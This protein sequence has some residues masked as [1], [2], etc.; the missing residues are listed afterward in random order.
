MMRRDFEI[1]LPRSFAAVAAHRSFTRAS[2]VIGR[3]QSV[4]ITH[5]KEALLGYAN[6]T[7]AANDGALSHLQRSEA[8]GLV[9]IDAPD[10]YATL[11]LQPILSA[12]VKVHPHLQFKVTCDDPNDLLPMLEQ[13]HFDVVMAPHRP[14]TVAGHIAR[15][16]PLHRVTSPDFIDDSD[17]PLSLVLFPTGCA[18][19][20]VALDVLKRIERPWRVTYSMRRIG[21][22]EKSILES[23]SLS[24]MEHFGSARRSEVLQKC[25]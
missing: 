16:E 14:K 12:I 1:D 3:T 13:G 18:C 24:V 6:R 2:W 19:R 5:A 8:E 23:S 20:D 10:D 17:V 15:Y 21:L 22:M 4:A 11:L 9:R 25:R 7:L